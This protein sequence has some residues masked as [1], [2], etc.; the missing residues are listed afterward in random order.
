MYY[1]FHPKEHSITLLIDCAKCLHEN[2]FAH[3]QWCS[4]SASKAQG[5][6]NSQKDETNSQALWEAKQGE[7]MRDLQ[8]TFHLMFLCLCPVSAEQ[9]FDCLWAMP[10]HAVTIKQTTSA[11]ADEMLRVASSLCTGIGGPDSERCRAFMTPLD[12]AGSAL[13]VALEALWEC[14]QTLLFAIAMY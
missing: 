13:S 8:M 12:S 7:K 11:G 6:H 10:L 14:W 1:T 5:W 4:Q 2:L 3:Q 9:L